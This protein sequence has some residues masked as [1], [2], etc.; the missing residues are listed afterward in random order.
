[1]LNVTFYGEFGDRNALGILASDLARSLR[2][3]T[4][5]R[6][7]DVSK[8]RFGTPADLA[9]LLVPNG[10]NQDS[11]GIYFGWPTRAK[12][13]LS[14]H[15][16][17][18]GMFLADG[19]PVG[20]QY[21]SLANKYCTAAI[22]PST[23]SLESYRKSG[24]DLPAEVV[25]YGVWCGMTPRPER[26]APGNPF[27]LGMALLSD[28]PHRK[29]V[30][31][32]IQAVLAADGVTL[33]IGAHK[34]ISGIPDA[35]NVQQELLAF[36][37][38]SEV[39]YWYKRF[40]AILVPSRCEGAGMVAKEALCCGVP[41]IAT[42]M[43][44]HADY[45][46]RPGAVLIRQS[47][48][49]VSAKSYGTGPEAQYPDVRSVD[50]LEAISE[51]VAN[52]DSLEHAARTHAVTLLSESSWVRAA[53]R[54]VQFVSGQ[55]MG[56]TPQEIPSP[57][58][59]AYPTSD[60]PSVLV[61]GLLSSMTG[62]GEVARRF[63]HALSESYDVFGLDI[64]GGADNV[65]F[66]YRRGPLDKLYDYFIYCSPLT[67]TESVSPVSARQMS[68]SVNSRFKLVLTAGIEC[69]RMHQSG[70]DLVNRFYDGVIATSCHSL[71]A[72]FHVSRRGLRKK[73]IAIT[74]G[75]DTRDFF[76]DP[77]GFD[78][79]IPDVCLLVSGDVGLGGLGEDRKQIWRTVSCFYK[80]FGDTEGVGLVLKIQGGAFNDPSRNRILSNIAKLCDGRVPRNI[81]L[82][83]RRLSVS[84]MRRLYSDPRVHALVS[85]S[86]G[87][88]FGLHMIEAAACG[89]PIACTYD[90]GP[91][92]FLLPDVVRKIRFSK[93][94]VSAPYLQCFSYSFSPDA[95]WNIPNAEHARKVMRSL[96]EGKKSAPSAMQLQHLLEHHSP[97][98]VR[99]KAESFL[100]RFYW[101]SA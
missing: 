30:A 96:V 33:T 20:I 77:A 95:L 85:L 49:L 93:G 43:T 47:G 50:I 59:R 3:L 35:R 74:A 56:F 79:D 28:Y 15:P 23:W 6:I 13:L 90:M 62:Y 99:S 32:T 22:F 83:H 21:A 94:P 29:A 76:E 9:N 101:K 2:W 44:G 88:G 1:M 46:P 71:R 82:I 34:K 37:Y 52:Y 92:D 58:C 36:R 98:V 12:A 60:K 40:D 7:V 11:V 100:E 69:D 54:I 86:S 55:S 31:E 51:A 80:E 89:L 87:E 16:V 97:D 41:V 64:A 5:L 18:I 61:A 81:H 72:Y 48:A 78:E 14:K 25:P 24:F 19:S 70:I 73:G 75:V 45:L 84:E 42:G 10:A 17:R 4:H 26:N 27:R 91:K 53:D 67:S 65:G 63:Y 57:V 39:A 66:L 68:R 8:N 38:P